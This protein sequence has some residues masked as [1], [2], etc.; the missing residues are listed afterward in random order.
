MVALTPALVRRRST[1]RAFLGGRPP[2]APPSLRRAISVLRCLG[3][4]FSRSA[5]R[6]VRGFLSPARDLAGWDGC[7]ALVARSAA[8]SLGV[9]LRPSAVQLRNLA[10]PLGLLWSS[11]VPPTPQVFVRCEMGADFGKAKVKFL[12]VTGHV[13]PKMNSAQSKFSRRARQ[14]RVT[15]GAK[16]CQ[17][18]T[19]LVSV[20]CFERAKKK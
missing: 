3:P 9:D 6:R 13:R 19:S 16:K 8:L 4:R 15:K 17:K 20:R 11:S 2:C 12:V 5:D 18:V 10:S 14:N 1:L 7:V